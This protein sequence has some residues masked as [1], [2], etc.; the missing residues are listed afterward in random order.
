MEKQ[1]I[2]RLLRNRTSS[3]IQCNIQMLKK[4]LNQK[5]FIAKVKKQNYS[6]KFAGDDRKV[7]NYCEEEEYGYDK[8]E[9]DG[10]WDE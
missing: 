1:L 6:A 7:A 2:L 10:C 3:E 9:Y 5:L 8:K 4:V